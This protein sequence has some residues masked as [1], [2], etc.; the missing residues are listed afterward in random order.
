[1]MHDTQKYKEVNIKCCC[2]NLRKLSRAVTQYFDR[3]L[4]STDIRATQFTL[5][6]ELAS[7]KAKTLTE[8][9]NG[10]VM[11]RTTLTRNL[12]PLEKQGLISVVQQ[13]DKRSK[14]YALT[15]KGI[16]LLER[17]YPLWESAQNQIVSDTG[18]D[19]YKALLAEVMNMLSLPC[20]NK[21][22]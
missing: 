17:C 8:I 12:K 22:N 19:R 2:F 3:A 1:M 7:A 13:S 5:L 11:D 20:L 4:E 16:N 14:G 18:E 9:A 15:E 10:L 6:V 21:N